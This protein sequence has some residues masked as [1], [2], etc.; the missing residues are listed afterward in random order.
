[1]AEPI[2]ISDVAKRLG[3]K[4]DT[5]ANLAGAPPIVTLGAVRKMNRALAEQWIEGN[6]A[7]S[8]GEA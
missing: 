6:I 1:M 4:T 3:I 5:L 2:N 7:K 8:R